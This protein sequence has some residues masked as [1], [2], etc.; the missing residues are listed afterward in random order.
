MARRLVRVSSEPGV[1]SVFVNCLEIKKMMYPFHGLELMP[2]SG[3]AD[4]IWY[5]WLGDESTPEPMHVGCDDGV[6]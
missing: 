3:H 5:K 2:E 6:V 1:I 4:C